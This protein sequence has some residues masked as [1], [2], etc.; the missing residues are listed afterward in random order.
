[1]KIEY[2]PNVD[3][4][5]IGINMKKS[6]YTIELTEHILVDVT[7]DMKLVGIEILDASEEISK[8]FNRAVSKD[9]IKHMLC[10][11]KQEPN[12]YIVRFKSPQKNESANLFIPVYRSP[13][14]S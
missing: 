3:V 6:D 2:D 13:I 8:M 10:E 1:M 4:I 12:E 5:G 9:E 11:I 14:L 7:N